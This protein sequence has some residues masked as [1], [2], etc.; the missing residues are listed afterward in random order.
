MKTTNMYIKL[1][2]LALLLCL[3]VVPLTGCSS[4]RN[5]D[6]PF[7]IAFTALHMNTAAVSDYGAMLV[8]EM[9]ELVIDGNAPRFT[10]IVAGVV[11]NDPES[12]RIHDPMMGIAGMVQI[13][14]MVTAR[15]LDVVIAT[16]DN[17]A[18]DARG[19]MFLPLDEIFTPE[20]LAAFGDRLISFEHV[21]IDGPYTRP[22]GEMTPICGINIAGNEHMRQIFGE[23]EIGVFIVANSRNVELAREVMLSL[24]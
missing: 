7:Q 5:G 14:L 13:P 10:P 8:N 1:I 24:V 6:A 18:R 21:E 17:A 4:A 20:E 23:Q 15:E 19:D 16:L 3:L 2:S 11:E 22:T 12:G 9:P